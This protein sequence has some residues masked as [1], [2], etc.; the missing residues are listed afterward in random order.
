MSQMDDSGTGDLGVVA[1]LLYGYVLS[2]TGVLS[3]L[4]TSLVV[5]AALI[6]QDVNPQLKG[7]LKGAANQGA[8]LDQIRAVREVVLA[9]CREAGMRPSTARDSHGWGWKSDVANL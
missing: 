4:E 2:N 1:R 7:H 3:G 5:L 8:T 6:P 9:I